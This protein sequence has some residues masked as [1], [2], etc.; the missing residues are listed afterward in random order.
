MQVISNQ[1]PVLDIGPK[2]RRRD[3]IRAVTSLDKTE[4]T[5]IFILVFAPEFDSLG[6]A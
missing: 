4:R 3:A 2:I 1:T 6:C 5:E